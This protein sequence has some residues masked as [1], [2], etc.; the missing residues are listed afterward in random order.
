MRI[1]W[2]LLAV[3]LL[4]LGLGPRPTAAQMDTDHA[5]GGEVVAVDPANRTLTLGETVFHVPAEIAGFRE[6]V[7]GTHV[8]VHFA[9]Q[10]EQFTVKS[11][12]IEAH[13]D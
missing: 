10:G 2:V 12:E 3:L 1:R 5:I 9:V 11:L 6:V 7:P 4:G 13:T 8:V